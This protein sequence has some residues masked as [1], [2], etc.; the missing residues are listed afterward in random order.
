[1]TAVVDVTVAGLAERVRRV[2][3]GSTRT[4]VGLA[5]PPGAGKSTVAEA[6]VHELSPDAV[7]VPMDG[8]HL[9]N[10]VL[11]ALGRRD[12]KGAPDTFDAAGYVALLR[13]LRT[14]G[15]DVV[16]APTFFRDIEEPIGS[17]IPIALD[18][19]IVVTEGNYLLLDTP[20]WSQVRGLLDAA[21]YLEVD[22][23]VRLERLVARHIAYDKPP[24]AARA[25]AEGTDQRNAE[26]VAA[27]ARNA[28]LVL[29]I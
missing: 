29:R 8:F 15:R 9:S 7:L 1:M 20:P 26:A 21:W 2:A 13:R 4:I 25:W 19:P 17:S 27:S 22:D 28:D 14:P 18:T 23:A 24:E 3:A 6:L 11:E 12:R 16:Y 10:A 5:G